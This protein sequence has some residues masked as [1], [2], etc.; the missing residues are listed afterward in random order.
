MGVRARLFDM[1]E[2]EAGEDWEEL[3]L[4]GNTFYGATSTLGYS[5]SA[6]GFRFSTG[7]RS[8]GVGQRVEKDTAYSYEFN[9][10]QVGRIFKRIARR[11]FT[12]SSQDLDQLAPFFPFGKIQL[13]GFTFRPNPRF[14]I[15]KRRIAAYDD[16]I[17]AGQKAW[18]WSLSL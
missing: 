5:L 7:K 16:G 8:D 18:Y 11:D 1:F 17:R 10:L 12:S 6:L 14:V 4:G 15:G 3:E 13:G 2:A 9:V